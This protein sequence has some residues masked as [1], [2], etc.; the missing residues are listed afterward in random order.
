MKTATVALVV[1]FE[2]KNPKLVETISDDREIHIFET[3]CEKGT[4]DPIEELML[5]RRLQVKE[6]EDFGEYVEELLC[7]P[8]VRTEVQEHAVKWLKSK[9]RID[10][11]QKSESDA[12]RIIADYAYRIFRDSPEK[13]DFMLVGFTA[14]VRI[15]VFVLSEAV[16]HAA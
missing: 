2:D 12:A 13:T 15:R 11:F 8:C 5:F 14:K 4:S 1:R 3:A 7:Q 6:E 10:Q 16:Q 9:I